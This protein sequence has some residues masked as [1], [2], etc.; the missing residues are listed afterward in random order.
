MRSASKGLLLF[1]IAGG[2]PVLVLAGAQAA[3]GRLASEA[4]VRSVYSPADVNPIPD[5][6]DPFWR[7]VPPVT[8]NHNQFGIAQPG[9]ATEFRTRWTKRYLYFLFVCPYQTLYLKP[10]PK[11][12]SDTVG[13]WDWDVGEVFLGSDFD[14]IRKYK[15]FEVSPQGEWVDL[16]IDLDSTH[17]DDAWRWNSGFQVAARIDRNAK[18]WYGAMKIPYRSI[19]ARDPK[20]GLTLRANLYRIE[21]PEPDRKY[22][23]WRPTHS[24]TFHTPAA[25][26]TLKL[27]Q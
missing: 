19:D 24:H 17:K 14:D 27:V 22:I 21:G 5:P 2:L 18:I 3:P 8:S 16:D 1:A 4:V 25:F 26:G 11:T 7:N 9:R 12:D 15:E 23:C 13:L 10:D 20:P 6:H